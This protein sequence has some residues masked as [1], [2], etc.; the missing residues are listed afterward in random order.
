MKSYAN[1]VKIVISWTGMKIACLVSQQTVT[2]ILSNLENNKNFLMKYIE[3]EEILVIFRNRNFL[4]NPQG[5]CYNSKL[6]SDCNLDKDLRKDEGDNQL[7]KYKDT[8]L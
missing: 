5:L 8:Y 7:V 2:R 3:M 4:R 1:S 6:G